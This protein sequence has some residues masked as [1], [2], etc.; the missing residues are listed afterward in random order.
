M[1]DLNNVELN[2]SD[3]KIYSYFPEYVSEVKYF[4]LGKMFQLEKRSEY[5]EFDKN[6]KDSEQETYERTFTS[7]MVFIVRYWEHLNY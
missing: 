4:L 6:A 5:V 2:E 1:N 7:N 3:I